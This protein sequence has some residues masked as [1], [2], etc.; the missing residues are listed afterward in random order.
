MSYNQTHSDHVMLYVHS[1][2]YIHKGHI[3]HSAHSGHCVQDDH[4]ER[5]YVMA[6]TS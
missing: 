4:N 6:F 3:V 5:G 2:Q 1:V